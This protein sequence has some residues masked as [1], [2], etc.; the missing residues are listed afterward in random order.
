MSTSLDDIVISGMSGR[1]P[2]SDSVD[3]FARNLFAGVDLI[4][5]S[6]SRW[7]KDFCDISSRMARIE[8]YDRFDANFFGLTTEVAEDLDPQSRM[9][10]EVAFEAIM[11]SD[12]CD[13]SS[14]MARIESYDRFDANFFGL[15]TEVAEDLDPQSRML[16]EV[17]FEAIMDSANS[18]FSF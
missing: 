9:L 16:L 11:D 4:T 8:S 14:R 1:F 7:P 10:L 17:A 18:Y 15:T 13:I 5:E 3:E 2:L 6:D 12:F